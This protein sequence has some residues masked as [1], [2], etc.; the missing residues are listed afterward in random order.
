LIDTITKELGAAR[1][2]CTS[3][4][5]DAGFH[6]QLGRAAEIIIAC[7]RSGGKVLLAGNGGS[8]ADAQHLASEFVS[9]YLHE[10]PGLAAVALNANGSTLTAIANDY[11]FE[12]VFKRQIEAL[13]RS[14]DVFVGISTSGNSGNILA[15]AR[16]ARQRGLRVIGL[17]G[18][19]G[20]QLATLCDECL[21][22][23]TTATP[24]IQQA[25]ILVGHLLCL[26][27]EESL[28]P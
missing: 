19:G 3:L 15:A 1:A 17:T 18:R 10:R 7:Y 23:P 27:V 2:L 4:L 5:E 16:E 8:A 14:G 20:G 22:I 26:L 9:R 13:G 25:H 11:G 12:F 24:H 28:L 21:C 6:C